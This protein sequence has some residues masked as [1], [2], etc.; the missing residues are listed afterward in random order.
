MIKAG[1]PHESPPLQNTQVGKPPPPRNGKVSQSPAGPYL[2]LRPV[3]LV[4]LEMHPGEKTLE[5]RVIVQEGK[6]RIGLDRNQER[7]V[8]S[9]GFF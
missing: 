4:R 9:V 5:S 7:I 2:K 3:F 8:G 1:G 6:D